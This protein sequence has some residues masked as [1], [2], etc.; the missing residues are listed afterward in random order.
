VLLKCESIREMHERQLFGES[1]EVI[2]VALLSPELREVEQ[3]SG[4]RSRLL[5]LKAVALDLSDQPEA[6]LEIFADLVRRYPG[7]PEFETSL[8]IGCQH[9]EG[10][11]KEFLGKNPQDPRARTALALLEQYGLPSYWLIHSV[12]LQEAADGKVEQAWSRI[13]SLLATS[14]NDEDYLRCALSIA[15]CG[16]LAARRQELLAHVR[17]LWEARPYRLE[18]AELLRAEGAAGEAVAM[19]A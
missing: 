14:P 12:A 17:A 13:S 19:V 10:T 7:T 5:Y 16:E 8:Q 15:G 3:E 6:A 11:A 1:L 18:L 4:A 2:E 9:L